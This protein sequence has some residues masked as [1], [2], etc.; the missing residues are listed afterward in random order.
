MP[1][2]GGKPDESTAG[3]EKC[4]TPAPDQHHCKVPGLQIKDLQP[5]RGQRKSKI[6]GDSDNMSKKETYAPNSRGLEILENN[7]LLRIL[8]S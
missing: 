5:S 7:A 6:E 8:G 1:V 4:D 3:R 2:L